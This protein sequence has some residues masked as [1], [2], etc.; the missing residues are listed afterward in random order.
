MQR[1]FL[2][3]ALV[4]ASS[5]SSLVAAVAETTESDSD[6]RS[7][8]NWTELESSLSPA[9]SLIDTSYEKFR[10][11]CWSEFS[12]L[13]YLDYSVSPNPSTYNLI[14]R[15]SGVCT[16]NFFLG[17]DTGWPRPSV[18]GHLNG[19]VDQYVQ[20]MFDPSAFN[21]IVPGY[22][23][24]E[25]NPSLNIPPK[26]LFPSVASDVIKSIKFAKEN[27]VEISVKN[28]GHSYTSASSK[29][30]TLNLN[31]NRYKQYAPDGITD[32]DAALLGD[33]VAKDLSNQACLLALARGKPAVIRVGGGEN[34]GKSFRVSCFM[35]RLLNILSNQHNDS[36]MFEL[37]TRF[38]GLL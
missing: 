38:T 5:P 22:I 15:P 37:Q 1:L 8:L 25:T 23:S 34:F 9:A 24:D 13:A 30:D 2:L 27:T 32:C 36:S 16:P 28:S 4:S 31:M 35:L 29:K 33:V 21:E 12:V 11:E 19:T 18:D 26:V 17:W 20:E 14:D 6:W 7:D 10:D 3:T